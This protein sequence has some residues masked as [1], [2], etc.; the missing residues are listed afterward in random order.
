MDAHQPLI[1]KPQLIE[2][3]DAAFVV[4]PLHLVGF[5]LAAGEMHMDRK[6]IFP[7]V[8]PHFQQHL[9]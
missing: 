2:Q 9:F 1:Q 6:L 3:R 8:F 5:P 7:G 4:A